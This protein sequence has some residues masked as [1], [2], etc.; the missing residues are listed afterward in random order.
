MLR[1]LTCI[2]TRV[3]F[4]SDKIRLEC[5]TKYQEQYFSGVGAQHHNARE[6]ISIQNIMYMSSNFMVHYSLHWT[7]HGADHIFLWSFVVNHAVWFHNF[8]PNYRS[9]ITP[10]EFLTSNKADHCNLSI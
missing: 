8:M 10:L 7:D 1:Y 9:R 3:F 2:V 5:D 6:E 4:A